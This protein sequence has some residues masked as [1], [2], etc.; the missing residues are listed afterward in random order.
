MVCRVDAGAGMEGCA[1][2]VDSSKT[3]F[4]LPPKKRKGSVMIANLT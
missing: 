3:K 2:V 4:E 1:H